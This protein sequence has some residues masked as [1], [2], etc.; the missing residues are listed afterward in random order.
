VGKATLRQRYQRDVTLAEVAEVGHT[1]EA[2]GSRLSS[3]WQNVQYNLYFAA[4][5]LLCLL[6]CV[7]RDLQ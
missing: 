5:H 4:E 2:K 7:S 3:Q 6:I 1:G